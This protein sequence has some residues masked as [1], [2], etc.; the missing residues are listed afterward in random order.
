M[1]DDLV[2]EHPLQP[3]SPRYFD[4]ADARLFSYGAGHGRGARSLRGA[5]RPSPVFIAR[6]LPPEGGAECAVDV[7]ELVRFFD[8]PSRSFLQRRL[9]LFLGGD[10]EALP[11]R[12]PLFLAGLDRWRVGDRL[13]AR[14]LRGEA[15]D[16]ALAL[17]AAQGALPYGALGRC[18]LASVSAVT[19]RLGDEAR[20]YLRGERL[21]P[22]AVD[23][24]IGGLRIV[25][26]LRDV[27][28]AAQVVIGF[29]KLRAKHHLRVWIRHLL[30]AAG[31]AGRARPSVAIGRTPSGDDALVRRLRPADDADALLAD[32]VELFEIGRTAPLPFFPEISFKYVESLRGGK[33]PEAAL[34]AAAERYAGEEN[35]SEADDP[36]VGQVYGSANPI[37][38]ARIAGVP[39]FAA[40]ALRV[41]EPLLDHVEDEA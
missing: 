13:L 16:D 36:Y 39:D 29:S 3:F 24:R 23:R 32:L 2:V 28:P 6:R 20:P 41:W 17:L 33:D 5:R 1:R 12:E 4:G 25:G 26:A 10:A 9:A 34:E 27:W 19:R 14:L 35:Y 11:E 31:G 18:E 30:L 7:D 37:E 8:N 38:G 40:V 22:Q 15:L 21:P